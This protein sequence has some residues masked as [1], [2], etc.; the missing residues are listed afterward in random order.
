MFEFIEAADRKKQMQRNYENMDL[1]GENSNFP[2]KGL[3]SSW[4]F[5][6]PGMFFLYIEREGEREIDVCDQVC[7]CAYIAVQFHVLENT[8]TY[9]GTPKSS[10]K[11]CFHP[12][13][14]R[15]RQKSRR[16]SVQRA[17]TLQD[18]EAARKM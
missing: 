2:T 13:T 18:N 4:L 8:L 9:H 6:V 10:S 3:E 16:M 1:F 7:F 15:L 14:P 11:S 17:Q 12:L 5:A